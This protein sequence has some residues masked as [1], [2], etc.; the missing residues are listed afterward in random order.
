MS[1]KN[2]SLDRAYVP[3]IDVM[4]TFP[5]K[6]FVEDLRNIHLSLYKLQFF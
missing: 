6:E 4:Y 5:K 2:V 3:T 1:S